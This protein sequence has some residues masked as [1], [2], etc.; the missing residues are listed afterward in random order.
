[1]RSSA[2]FVLIGVALAEPPPH[3]IYILTDNLGWGNVGYH[4][5]GNPEV[6]TPTLDKMVKTGVDLDRLYAYKYW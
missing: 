6:L 5:L 4:R 1:M 3:I 2:L